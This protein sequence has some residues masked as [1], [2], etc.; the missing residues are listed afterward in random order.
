MENGVLNTGLIKQVFTVNYYNTLTH[1]E[2]VKVRNSNLSLIKWKF[3]HLC[4]YLVI[5]ID[6]VDGDL[7]FI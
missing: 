4:G 2:K 7:Q 5:L 1:S 6:E 3:I